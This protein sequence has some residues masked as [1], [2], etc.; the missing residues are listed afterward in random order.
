MSGIHEGPCP[1]CGGAMTSAAGGLAFCAGC[2]LA[3][4]PKG[5]PPDYSGLSEADI[6][7]V[8]KSRIFAEA[9]E[10]LGKP[11]RGAAL[12]DVGCA[13]GSFMAAASAA[14]WRPLGVEISEE[15]ARR[16]SGRGLEVKAGQ[17]E[18]LRLASGSFGAVCLL[19]VLSL[20]PDPGIIAAEAFRLLEPGGILLVRELNAGFHLRAG[21]LG[22]TPGLSALGLSP[23]VV[24][25]WNFGPASLRALLS[26]RGFAAVEVSNSRPTSGDPYGTGGL[27]GGAFVSVFKA[28]YWAAAEGLRLLTGGRVLA[29]TALF[30]VGRKPL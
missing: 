8:S 6:Y 1:A 29:A 23:G 24:H 12:L 2:G 14:G 21:R 16:A 25:P 15:L 27:L 19:D 18:D 22:D 17:L 26:G 11:R 13:D 3:A 20:V 30:A 28:A 7:S 10:L 9:L 5:S 4:G